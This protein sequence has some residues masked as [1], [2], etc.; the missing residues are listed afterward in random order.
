MQGKGGGGRGG[1]GGGGGGGRRGKG[2]A[3]GRGRKK[4]KTSKRD[5]R[6]GD[7]KFD[8]NGKMIDD[9]NT[10]AGQQL[11]YKVRREELSYYLL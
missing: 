9:R 10:E 3:A 8:E 4:N 2:S 6:L 7:I 11:G 5:R 1:V